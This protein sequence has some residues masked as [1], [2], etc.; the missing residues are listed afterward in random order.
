MKNIARIE[1]HYTENRNHTVNTEYRIY[2]DGFTYVAKTRS[3]MTKAEKAFLNNNE[4]KQ[5]F[6]F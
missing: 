2:R 4:A 1:I 3:Q 6:N 5:I